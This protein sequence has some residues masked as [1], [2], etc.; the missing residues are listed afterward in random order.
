MV[1][2][3][4]G[5]MTCHAVFVAPVTMPDKGLNCEADL[6]FSRTV[7]TRSSNTHT[8]VQQS[9]CLARLLFY[10]EGLAHPHDYIFSLV[11]VSVVVTFSGVNTCPL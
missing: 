8:S 3:P 9:A 4:L 7:V 11:V 5:P 2:A 1:G 6:K 10:F